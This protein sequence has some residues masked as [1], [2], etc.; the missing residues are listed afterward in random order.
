MQTLFATDTNLFSRRTVITRHEEVAKLCQE[1]GV[2]AILHNRPHRNDAIRIGLE[3]FGGH[4]PDGCMFC[5]CDQP[6]L[7]KETV[8]T[9]GRAFLERPDGI[10]RLSWQNTPGSPIIFPKTYF[11]ALKHLPQG[12]GGS[13]VIQTSAAEVRYVEAASAWELRDVDTVEDLKL[14]E[15]STAP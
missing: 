1:Y 12:K 15:S 6:L 2:E 10:Y 7:P 8:E 5:P 4:L 14:L 13:Y 11:A 3:S 9:L